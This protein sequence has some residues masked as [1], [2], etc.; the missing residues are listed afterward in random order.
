MVK[1]G[2]ELK[3][4]TIGILLTELLDKLFNSARITFKFSEREDIKNKQKGICKIC[5]D[6][7]DDNI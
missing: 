7:I 3:N 6:I 5:N 1:F 4:Q 2:I